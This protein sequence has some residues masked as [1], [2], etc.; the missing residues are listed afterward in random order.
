M[1]G[2]SAKGRQGFGG[3]GGETG[4]PGLEAGAVD[5]IAHQRVADMGEM[6]P[7]LMGAAGL[8]PAGEELQ[9]RSELPADLARLRDALSSPHGSRE[10]VKPEPKKRKK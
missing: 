7:D 8:Q 9:F 4:G 3:L 1:E 2:L 6:D 5:R 10:T